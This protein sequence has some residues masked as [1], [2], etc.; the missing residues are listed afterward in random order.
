MKRKSLVKFV[1]AA[2]LV[3]ASTAASA[4]LML[5]C[6]VGSD[7]SGARYYSCVDGDGKTYVMI[8]G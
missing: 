1:L 5:C 7:S 3:L 8:I 2:A 4:R 6:Y